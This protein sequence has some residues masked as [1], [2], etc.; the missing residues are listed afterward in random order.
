[1]KPILILSLCLLALGCQA[2]DWQAIPLYGDR[3]IPNSL[4]AE[5]REKTAINDWGV[6]FTTEISVPE[7]LYFPP[8]KNSGMAVVICPGGGYSGTATD[9]EG[10][11]VAKAFQQAGISAFVLKYRI[12]DERYCVDKSLA[13]LQ[14][15]QQALRLIRQ[16]AGTWQIRPDKIGIL[17]F[18]AG[19][20]LA[21][22]AATHFNFKADA[23]Q[24][25]STSARPD[26]AILIYPVVSFTDSLGHGG[27]RA[28]LLGEAPSRDQIRFFSNELQVDQQ[29]PPAFLLHT[30]DDFV[31]VGNSLAYYQACLAKG[32]PAE[33]HL[34][35][36]GG[37]GYGLR[38]PAGEGSWFGL[39]LNWLEGISKS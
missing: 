36:R 15:A 25:D 6:A 12:P 26:F 30:Q 29:A 17:G 9:H 14:D 8:Q 28:R 22:T 27:S 38:H 10:I 35:P 20:H 4:P 33:M 11:Q 16:Q 31:K 23:I 5:N 37:H 13:P 24:E 1:M 2:Q 7:L 39:L 32:V 19:G 34:F 3:P 18:S 21:A